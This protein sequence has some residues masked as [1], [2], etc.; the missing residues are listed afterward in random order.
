MKTSMKRQRGS[1]AIELAVLFPILLMFVALP[2]FYSRCLWHYTVA[3]KAA[4][5]AA[6]YL[7]TLPKA[8]MTSPALAS[9]AAARATEIARREIAELA[10]GSDIIGPI[11]H[12]DT[13]DCG[14]L[15][16]AGTLPT[17]VKVNL[18]FTMSDPWFDI[19]L[20]NEI[21]ITATVTMNYVGS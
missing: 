16:P 4:Q 1:V 15:F 6:R 12:C 10:P 21:A 2:I 13:T 3:Q 9:A 18:W 17:T 19:V 20:W 7:A 5:D 8:E 11:A 14:F